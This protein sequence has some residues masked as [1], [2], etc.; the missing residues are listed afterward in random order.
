MK[1]VWEF[2]LETSTIVSQQRH[3]INWL[4]KSDLC[5]YVEGMPLDDLNLHWTAS[6]DQASF[7][8]V[9]F[10]LTLYGVGVMFFPHLP[11]P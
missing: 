6:Y 9:S 1:E 8:P 7:N 3:D 5:L 11:H 4:P 2:Y 10:I